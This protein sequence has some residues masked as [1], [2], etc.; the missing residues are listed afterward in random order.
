MT[1][2]TTAVVECRGVTKV[3]GEGPH[4]V[5]ALRGI[6]LTVQAGEVVMLVGPSGCG[7]TT[8]IS[9]IAGVLTPTGGECR[10]FGTDLHRLRDR[11]RTAFRG[12][13]IGFVFQQFNLIGTLSLREN[14]A[15]P[16]LINGVPYAT[17]VRD[18]DEA[19]ATVGLADRVGARPADLSGG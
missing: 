12:Q 14:V 9:T 7:K 8:L 19:L 5:Q 4:Q 13:R 2:L 17:A 3:F 11:A 16:L 1:E 6:D 15:V 10:V 18:A